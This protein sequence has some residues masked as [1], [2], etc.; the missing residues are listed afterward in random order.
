[1]HNR[2]LHDS[3]AAFVEEAAWQLAEE[4]SGGAEV[5]FE[6]I[7][8]GRATGIEVAQG[9]FQKQAETDAGRLGDLRGSL[10]DL[11]TTQH[12]LPFDVRDQPCVRSPRRGQILLRRPAVTAVRAQESRTWPTCF[13]MSVR[14]PI[15]AGSWRR[16]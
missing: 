6:L 8:Q 5:P 2:A 9:R 13:R 7:E 1:M 14:S 12:D 11:T 4:V 15:A 3:L 10:G 16:R